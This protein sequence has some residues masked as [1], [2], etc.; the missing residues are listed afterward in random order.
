MSATYSDP[1][2]GPDTVVTSLGSST[3]CT[4]GGESGVAYVSG[5]Q[6]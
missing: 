4:E 6:A 2:G 1:N 3:V 5:H